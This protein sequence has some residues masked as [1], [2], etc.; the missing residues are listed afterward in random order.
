MLSGCA[1]D[2][3]IM[4]ATERIYNST[5]AQIQGLIAGSY[6]NRRTFTGYNVSASVGTSYAEPAEHQTD[7]GYRVFSS[8]QG[9]INSETYDVIER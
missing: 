1:V 6:Q 7:G 3:S 5:M 9:N 8:L 2:G 4:D